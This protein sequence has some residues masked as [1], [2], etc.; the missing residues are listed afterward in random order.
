MTDS[1]KTVVDEE[2]SNILV[3]DPEDYS[4]TRKL[5][6]IQEAKDHYKSFIVD[7]NEWNKRLHNQYMNGQEAYERQRSEALAMI[8]SELLP[9]IERGL[10]KGGLSESDM[11]LEADNG[12][13]KYF[14]GKEVDIREIIESQGKIL[15]KGETKVLP[16]Y[17]QQKIYRQFERIEQKLGIGLEIEEEK[18]PAE[19]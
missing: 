11:K 10:E 9:L 17:F 4:K 15:H 19:I 18:D 1:E 12:V 5:K 2:S 8:G 7:E 6:S 14:N 16:R 3:V 13:Y